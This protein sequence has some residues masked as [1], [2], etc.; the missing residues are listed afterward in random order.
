MKNNALFQVVS[1]FLIPGYLFLTPMDRASN[2][3]S[4]VCRKYL[5]VGCTFADAFNSYEN[6]SI[7]IPLKSLSVCTCFDSKCDFKG[8]IF[9][10][11]SRTYRSHQ[12]RTD[13]ARFE[14]DQRYIK[15]HSFRQKPLF[16]FA[17]ESGKNKA[18]D[19]CHV[20]RI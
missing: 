15:I 12:I 20:L 7:Q 17:A 9:S 19:G 14:N 2:M 8:A 6:I 18:P 10:R 11:A 1:L 5:H 16:L 3:G 13:F 4:D